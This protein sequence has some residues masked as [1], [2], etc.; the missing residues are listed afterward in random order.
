MLSG[1]RRSTG[2]D[3]GVHVWH[4]RRSI[5]LVTQSGE[6]VKKRSTVN[7]VERPLRDTIREGSQHV[8]RPTTGELP[9]RPYRS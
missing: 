7:S 2:R 1:C 5:V 3:A 4:I 9:T 6:R 8:H